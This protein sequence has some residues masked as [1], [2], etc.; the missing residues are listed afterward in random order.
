MDEIKAGTRIT[1]RR[2]AELAKP[3]ITLG[4]LEA[5]VAAARQQDVPDAA[6]VWTNGAALFGPAQRLTFL[7]VAEDVTS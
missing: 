4:E 6:V 7:R 3:E 2:Y 1:E 5:F